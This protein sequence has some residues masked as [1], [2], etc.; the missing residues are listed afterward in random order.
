MFS[1]FLPIFLMLSLAHGLI[2]DSYSS[3][4][5]EL[6]QENTGKLARINEKS[7]NLLQ[8]YGSNISLAINKLKLQPLLTSNRSEDARKAFDLARGHLEKIELALDYLYVFVPGGISELMIHDQRH[9]NKFKTLMDLFGPS[10]YQLNKRYAEFWSL[11]DIRLDGSQK[12]FHKILSGFHSSFLE[13]IFIYSY[14]KEIAMKFG[15]SSS[16]FFYSVVFSDKGRIQSYVGFAANS[17]RL[18]RKFLERELN[19]MNAAGSTIFLA[20]E[21]LNNSDFTTFPYRKMNALNGQIGKKAMNFITKCRSSLFEKHITDLEHLY[22]FYPMRN[23]HKYAG[24]CVVS[25]AGINRERSLKRL[26]LFAITVLLTCMMYVMASFATSHMLTPLD[27]INKTLQKISNGNLGSRIEFTR[28][29]E[30]GKLGTAINLML[31]GFKHR[32][33]LG[34]FVSTTL[35]KSLA[36]NASLE[37]SIKARSVTGTVLFSDIRSFTT[38]S[39]N[40]PPDEIAAMLNYHLETMSESVQ[41]FGGQVEQFIG[42]AIVAFF[43]D[44]DSGDSKTRAVCAAIAMFNAHQAI[45]AARTARNQFE[46]AIGTGLAHGRIIAGPLIT[47]TRSEFCF[48]GSAKSEAELYEQQSK[49]GRHTRIVVAPAFS[50]VIAEISGIDCAALATTGLLELRV[51]EA[52]K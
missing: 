23:M 44:M 10:I 26:A 24:G 39:E 1:G 14:E 43:P 45:N 5:I 48:I 50:S 13:E 17:E 52:D 38:L 30:L 12:N 8:L 34:K 2:E 9:Y 16:D 46:Y 29:D 33:R 18:F 15:E 4:L 6:R 20:A 3:A 42:D 21:E 11:P 19:A 28:S 7:D 36:S 35:E 31:E 47:P 41:Q 51:K 25:L 40:W 27:E 22:I 49:L 37:E 32:L